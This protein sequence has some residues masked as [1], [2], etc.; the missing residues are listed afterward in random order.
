M[1]CQNQSKI[2]WARAREREHR[3]SKEQKPMMTL[4]IE[5][6]ILNEGGNAKSGF[7]SIVQDGWRRGKGIGRG[8]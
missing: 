8:R 5:I 7:S 2:N 6:Q 3:V 1:N 4:V